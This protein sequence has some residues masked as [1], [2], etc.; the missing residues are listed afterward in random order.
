M[1][2]VI[3][4]GLIDYAE[5]RELQLSLFNKALADKKAG[6]KPAQYFIVCEHPPVYTIGKSGSEENI[7]LNETMLG[8]P[9]YKIERGGDV[10]FHGR[11]Q[12]VGYPIVDLEQINIGL[13]QYIETLEEVI[14]EVI[15]AY[16]LNGERISTASGVWLDKGTSE[17][18]KICALG[19][20]ASRHITMHGFAFNVNTDLSWFQKINPCGF[21]DKGVTSLAKELKSE[22]DFGKVKKEVIEK[23]LELFGKQTA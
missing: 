17:V 5:A 6:I 4:K 10:T 13:K 8:A 11:G 14:I 15:A 2:E 22:Q 9:V 3:D 7:L 18:R 20:R 21:T 12:I 16:G 1:I 23:F 19:V